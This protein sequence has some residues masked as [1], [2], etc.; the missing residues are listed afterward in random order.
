MARDDDVAASVLSTLDRELLSRRPSSS[1]AGARL[2]CFTRIESFRN[3]GP[4]RTGDLPRLDHR[5]CG[6]TGNAGA[7]CPVTRATSAGEDGV[8]RV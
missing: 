7:T 6:P 1:R 4:P 5:T 3:R 8:D 2:A